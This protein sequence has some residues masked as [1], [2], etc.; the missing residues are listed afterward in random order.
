MVDVGI[1][2]DRLRQ[3]EAVVLDQAIDVDGA[4]AVGTVLAGAAGVSDCEM[5][6]LEAESNR[7]T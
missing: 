2:L 4:A 6:R 3:A 1:E 5:R 7:T